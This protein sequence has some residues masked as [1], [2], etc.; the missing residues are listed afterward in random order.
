M[1]RGRKA[2]N[3]N[4]LQK[5]TVMQLVKRLLPRSPGPN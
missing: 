1:P 5:N 4:W 3:I 2:K